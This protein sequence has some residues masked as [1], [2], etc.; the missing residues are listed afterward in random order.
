MLNI[1][2]QESVR[3]RL[4][5]TPPCAHASWLGQVELFFSIMPRRLLRSGEFASVEDLAR[6][7][8]EIINDYNRKAK[9]FKWTYAGRPL[10]VA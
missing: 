6:R 1:G 2:S 4:S 9:P 5:E 7:I 8:I 3:N 10:K